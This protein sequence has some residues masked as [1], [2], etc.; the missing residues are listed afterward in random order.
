MTRFLFLVGLVA[1]GGQIGD[2]DAGIDSSTKDAAKTPHCEL[3]ASDYDTSC[4]TASDCSAVFLGNACT[5]TC[6]CENAVISSSSLAAYQADY[7]SASDG[8]SIVCP[9]PPIQPPS[10]CKGKCVVGT[11]P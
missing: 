4:T 3:V 2:V 1:C 6:A 10:C 9:C 5:A 11:C 8:G 7:K